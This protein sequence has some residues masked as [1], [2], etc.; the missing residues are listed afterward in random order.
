MQHWLAVYSPALSATSPRTS[1]NPTFQAHCGVLQNRLLFGEDLQIRHHRVWSLVCHRLS[2]V[3]CSYRQDL[4]LDHAGEGGKREWRGINGN[5][6]H[7]PLR[8]SKMTGARRSRPEFPADLRLYL[9]VM[10]IG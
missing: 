5:L 10:P 6:P 7:G 1:E 2:G 3:G 9:A 8:G 4:T